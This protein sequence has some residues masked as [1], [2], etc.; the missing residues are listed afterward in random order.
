MKEQMGWPEAISN[1]VA[2]IVVALMVV[3]VIYSLSSCFA[4]VALR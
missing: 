1:M 3:G 4:S 2:N